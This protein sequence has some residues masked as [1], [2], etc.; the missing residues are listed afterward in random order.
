[1]EGIRILLVDDE[2]R[3][4]VSASKV[5]R[6]KGIETFTADS[7]MTAL[8]ML[9][10][11]PIDVVV[12][13]VKMPGLSGLET[14]KKIKQKYPDIQVILLTGHATTESA[15]EGMR[16]GACGYLVKPVDLDELLNKA[17][18]ACGQQ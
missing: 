3:F 11:D 14:L 18:N 15:E 12:L 7:G 16:Y 10:S 5:F 17:K 2:K 1:M 13:D 6:H 9:H 4:L 8:K